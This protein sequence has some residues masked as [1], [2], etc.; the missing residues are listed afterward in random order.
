MPAA[1]TLTA[2]VT[3]TRSSDDRIRIQFFDDLSGIVFAKASMS[4]EAFGFAIT[5][6]AAQ[7]ADLEV[8]GLQWVGKARVSEARRVECPLATHDRDTLTAWLKENGQE[9]GWILDP[10]LSSQ[11]SIEW[12]NGK[13]F[14]NYRVFKYVEAD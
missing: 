12:A 1:Q 2:K 8:R 3:I 13:T 10:H 11:K 6:F 14:L 9:D 7:K 5:G 4:A